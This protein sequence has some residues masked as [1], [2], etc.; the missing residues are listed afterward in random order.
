MSLHGGRAR[1]DVVATC[2]ATDE[3]QFHEQNIANLAV[4]ARQRTAEALQQTITGTMTRTT[5]RTPPVIING[6]CSE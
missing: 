3:G 5:S 1:S 6:G 2:V 4:L